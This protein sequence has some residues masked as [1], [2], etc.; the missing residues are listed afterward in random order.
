MGQHLRKYSTLTGDDLDVGP[1]DQDL[2]A[3]LELGDT[4][5][6]SR[7]GI[8]VHVEDTPALPKWEADGA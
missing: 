1:E 5:A 3:I 7:P 6:T 8:I 2:D 4:I